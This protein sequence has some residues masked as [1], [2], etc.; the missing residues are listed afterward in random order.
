MTGAELRERLTKRPYRGNDP[1]EMCISLVAELGITRKMVARLML[2]AS[3]DV[4]EARDFGGPG[5]DIGGDC[6]DAAD[7]I[8]T[9]LDAAEGI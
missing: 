4:C 1:Q 7:A 5:D 3:R 2:G 8:A 6:Q 9:L